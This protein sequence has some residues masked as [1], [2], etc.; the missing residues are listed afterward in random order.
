MQSPNQPWPVA[1]RPF[2]DEA[3]GSWLGRVAARYRI[4]V[5]DLVRAAGVEFDLDHDVSRWLAT[6]APMERAAT[7]LGHL[8]RLSPVKLMQMLPA[9]RIE[10]TT[11]AYCYQCLIM[12]PL[13]VTAP[14]WKAVWLS[15][16]R[17]ACTAH[18]Q[19]AG[20][21][22]SAALRRNR[23]MRQLLRHVYYRHQ[24]RNQEHQ[25]RHWHPH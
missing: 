8:C 10:C 6:P 11:M 15:A 13:D 22:T 25:I 23:N 9:V 17:Q 4:G 21:I 14:Y 1:P 2:D 3:F 16:E 5:D 24:R 20:W 12:N 18:L 19:R 7:R